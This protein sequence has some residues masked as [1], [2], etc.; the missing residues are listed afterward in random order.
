MADELSELLGMNVD[1][2]RGMKSTITELAVCLQWYVDNDET[3]E[4]GFYG[5]GRKRAEA[6]L[7]KVKEGGEHGD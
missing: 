5:D 4:S 2:L 3:H 1:R 7:L 6:I